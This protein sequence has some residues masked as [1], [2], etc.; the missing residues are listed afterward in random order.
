VGLVAQSGR[1]GV[2]ART[3]GVSG[4]TQAPRGSP[5]Q[6]GVRPACQRLARLMQS[7]RGAAALQP[8]WTTCLTGERAHGCCCSCEEAFSV[9]RSL[10][11]AGLGLAAAGI[12]VGIWGGDC[13]TSA[14]R[15]GGSVA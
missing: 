2:W 10:R 11:A 3:R 9:R 6:S 1:L 8:A 12:W 13:H 14:R 4:S 5:A 7:S 15:P